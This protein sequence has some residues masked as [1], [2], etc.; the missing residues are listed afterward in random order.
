MTFDLVVLV[1]DKSIE[2]ALRELL[3]R[4]KHLGIRPLAKH[5]FIVHPERDP[6]VFHTGHEL[7]RPYVTDC[8]FALV[9]L[10]AAWEGAPS[11]EPDELAKLIEQKCA[12]LWDD[13]V[14][15]IVISPEL[16]AWVWSD[17][18]HVAKALGWNDLAS[19]R[20]WLRVRGFDWAP[21]HKP[22]DPKAAFEAAVRQAGLPPSSSIFGRLARTVSVQRCSDPAFRQLADVLRRWFPA[23]S[24]AQP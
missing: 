23:P 11:G 13:R 12:P 21:G 3:L 5:T 19:L 15:C 18:P 1:P 2:Q 20:S 22:G 14:R 8:S 6:G 16:E 9:C 24:T 7:L 4:D 10:D 17:S